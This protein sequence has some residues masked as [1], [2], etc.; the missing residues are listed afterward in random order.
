MRVLILLVLLCV[1]S[2][3][4]AAAANTKVE[5]Q[6]WS[7]DVFKQAA[8]TNK[9]VLLELEAVWCHWCHVMDKNTYSRQ[10]VADAIHAN[11]VP[12]RV[13][14]DA[15]P[16]LANRYREW[17]WPA[18]I[19]LKADGTELVKRAGYIAP[20]PFMRLLAAVVADPTPEA[21]DT[22]TQAPASAVS[23]LSSALKNQ[24]LARH[25]NTSD[26][27]LGGLNIAQKFIEPGALHYA[28][29]QTANP[30]ATGAERQLEAEI[31]SS[32]LNGALALIDP[33]W[34][35]AY[36]YSTG[37]DWQTPHFEKLLFTQARYLE[38]YSLAA[39]LLKD[40]RYSEASKHIV[41]YLKRFMLD[42][43]GAF[44]SSQD[45][46]LV[47]GEKSA[48]YFQLDD[49]ERLKRGVPRVDKNIYARENGLIATALLQWYQYSGKADGLVLAS[50]AVTAI[51]E[52]HRL[53]SGGYKHAAK[54]SNAYLEDQVAMAS[55]MLALYEVTAERDWLE[56]ALITA[57]F[58]EK[59]FKREGSGWL[60]A[61]DIGPLKPAP[62]IEQNIA[63][64]RFFNRLHHYSGQSRWRV[65]AE[66]AMR[67]L[68][69]EQVALKRVE[70]T[71][72]LLFDAELNAPPVHY[73]VVGKKRDPLAKALFQAA[74]KD[75]IAY[76]RVEWLDWSEGP[77]MNDD[78]P[79][80]SFQ[81]TAAYV[82]TDKRCSA[83][84][85]DLESWQV[86]RSNLVRYPGRE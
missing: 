2:N 84:A 74:L 76:K 47:P 62:G 53:Q 26:L 7:Q 33:A 80:P 50:N 44:Y 59:E 23:S 42:D 72:L 5:W 57:E 77:L 16:A 4:W 27:D 78:V 60:D 41:R 67:Y 43:S 70:E 75:P 82:C 14:H 61:R 71:G 9:L 81:N 85:F 1:Q 64:G 56:Q 86:R 52:T 66:H 38:G 36:Q 48:A 55:A 46:D 21:V 63:T 39:V 30:Y 13:D 25:I 20:D 49:R 40:A 31:A 54:Q 24:L 37:G 15:H 10:D 51:N 45:A 29:K 32:T 6:A 22:T 69:Q 11:Y 65:A 73:T 18:T 79:Y 83:P 8:K 19:I 68:A 17:G 3:V 28:L 34:G 12:V 35:G 58:I